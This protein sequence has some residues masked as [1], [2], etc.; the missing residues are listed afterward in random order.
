MIEK[1]EEINH[2][3]EEVGQLLAQQDV[4]KD[5]KKFTQL[6]K[7]YR[8]LEKVSELLHVFHHILLC[9]QLS[10]FFKAM[11]DFFQFFDHI[12]KAGGKVIN[13]RGVLLII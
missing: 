3:F 6:S 1:L 10:Y 4:V 9:Q 7:E 5:M 8:D 13:S 11:V 2:R 12:L